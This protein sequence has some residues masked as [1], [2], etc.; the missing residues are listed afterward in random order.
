MAIRSDPS[1]AHGY[2]PAE[3]LLGRKLVYPM[4]L[5]KNDIDLTGNFIFQNIYLR[6]GNFIFENIYLYISGKTFLL[7][8]EVQNLLVHLLKV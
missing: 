3:L 1:S 4:E 6:T 7:L 8:Y 5:S 2:A